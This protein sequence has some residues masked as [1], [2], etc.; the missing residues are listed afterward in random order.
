MCV[1]KDFMTSTMGQAT[2][3]ADRQCDMYC[4]HLNMGL[5][6]RCSLEGVPDTTRSLS[7][8]EPLIDEAAFKTPQHTPMRPKQSQLE[9]A[10]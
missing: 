1:L 4:Q 10:P 5:C 2:K 7:D 8:R 3:Q 9:P 6:R